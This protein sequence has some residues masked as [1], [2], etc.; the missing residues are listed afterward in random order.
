MKKRLV[1]ENTHELVWLHLK[2]LRS[3]ELCKRVILQKCNEEQITLPA[4]IIENKAIGV[5]SAVESALGYWKDKPN[6]LNSWV[7]SRYYALLQLTIAEQ[8]ASVKNHDDLASVQK[9]TEQ[10]HGLATF[11]DSSVP[12]PDGYKVYAIKA[13]HFY[14]YTKHLGLNPKQW[15]MDRRIR[16]SDEAKDEDKLVSIVDLF[17]RI[18]EISD[19]VYEHFAK[20]SLCLHVGHSSRNMQ[21]L[22]ERRIQRL[23]KGEDSFDDPPTEIKNTHIDIYPYETNPIDL[24]FVNSIGLPFQDIRAT[25]AIASEKEIFTGTFS[26]KGD[27][28]WHQCL[29]TYK[30]NYCGTSYIKPLFGEIQDPVITHFMLLYS[31]SIIVRYLPDLWYRITRGDLN[32]MHSLIEYYLTIFDDVVL[33]HVLERITGMNFLVVQPGSMNAPI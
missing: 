7:L 14:S 16:T 21:E 12:F 17:R 5:A 33:L 9:H 11:N 10:G 29:T 28:Y 20:P 3:S 19:I 13:G 1:G 6:D 26:H 8:V 31:L 32:H 22:S 2:R 15:S 27:K 24:E 18:P 25:K 4:E 30:S 23:Q